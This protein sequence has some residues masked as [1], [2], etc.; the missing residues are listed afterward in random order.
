MKQ[1][2]KN[3]MKYRKTRKTRG[4][5]RKSMNCS[6]LVE[7]AT[8]NTNTCYTL[9]I[10][11]KIQRAYNK[12]HPKSKI[13][14]NDPNEIWI[15]LKTRLSDC[16][17]ED[18]WL[19]QIKDTKMHEHLDNYIFAPDR[20]PEWDR[21]PNA[22]LS[23]IDILKVLKQYDKKHADFRFIGPTP[24]DFDNRPADY[25]GKCVWD[26]LCSFH[27]GDYLKRG[28]HKIGI[29]F[30]LDTHEGNGY[31]WVSLFIS[32]DQSKGFIGKNI[33]FFFDSA[34]EPA[35]QEIKKFVSNVKE[36]WL[37]LSPDN[38][39]NPIRDIENAPHVHQRGNT[40]CG[41]YSLIFIV[42]MLTG[43]PV[44]HRDMRREGG[45]K[46]LSMNERIHLF[47]K[48]LVTDK[49]AENYRNIFFNS[50]E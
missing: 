7:G 25:N 43:N 19:N 1:T 21:N 10:L 45:T 13:L 35:P 27:L 29:I 22:W 42:T 23:N 47:Q 31:H 48:G 37:N 32:I 9:P 14:S 24:I 4:G 18:C 8:A 50:P 5:N 20:P 49:D 28:I 39:K 15:S 30:N 6:P 17:K 26:E 33:A 11:R 44:K 38:V 46:H 36:Q 41:M 12:N 16:K 2:L 34:G 3:N 40:E